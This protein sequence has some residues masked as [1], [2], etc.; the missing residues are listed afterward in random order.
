MARDKERDKSPDA[1]GTP[2]TL[3]P[4]PKQR[5]VSAPRTKILE[6][7]GGRSLGRTL[8]SKSVAHVG[9]N[10]FEKRCGIEAEGAQ[11]P[12]PVDHGKWNIVYCFS[13]G[14]SARKS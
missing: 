8:K 14:G 9:Q 11:S 4:P 13:K 10:K 1:I 7:G 3:H 12:P 5:V 6:Q 2:P